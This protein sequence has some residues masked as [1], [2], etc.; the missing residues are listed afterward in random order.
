MAENL[1]INVNI[2]PNEQPTP[3]EIDTTP[4]TS[5]QAETPQ[6]ANNNIKTMASMLMLAGAAKNVG[7][8]TLGRVG[9]ITGNYA[10]QKQINTAVTMV[11][12][13]TAIAINP[14]AGGIFVATSIA[15][16]AIG[17]VVDQRNDRIEKDYYNT[18]TRN[19]INNNRW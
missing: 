13:G 12:Y 11:G 17:M 14:F 8:S 1:T 2:N 19:R 9:D 18:I 15:S 5:I 6:Q 7:M 3:T 16:K 10:L 4:T